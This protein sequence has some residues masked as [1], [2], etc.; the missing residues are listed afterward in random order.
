[1][2]LPL[3]LSPLLLSLVVCGWWWMVAASCLW[4]CAL[5]SVSR[6]YIA[7]YYCH[8]CVDVCLS[9]WYSN[10]FL[11]LVSL[12]MCAFVICASVLI[13]VSAMMLLLFYSLKSELWS[14]WSYE[15]LD[16]WSSVHRLAVPLCLW[17][18]HVCCVLFIDLWMLAVLLKF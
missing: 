10:I 9:A 3:Q 14:M 18:V 8:Y 16:H 13:I 7:L 4:A 6:C 1:M 12:L 2:C 11:T 17:Y 15:R 5:H